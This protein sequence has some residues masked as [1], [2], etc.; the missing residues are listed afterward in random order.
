LHTLRT[1]Y[2]L[3]LHSKYRCVCWWFF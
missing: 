3:G 2:C 1:K